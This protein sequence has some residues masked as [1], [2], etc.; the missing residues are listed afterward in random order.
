MKT[1]GVFHPSPILYMDSG[2]SRFHAQTCFDLPYKY[3]NPGCSSYKISKLASRQHSIVS[4]NLQ[5]LKSLKRSCFSSSFHRI[6]RVLHHQ[7]YQNN[8]VLT[9]M[10]QF[11]CDHP[12]KR[13]LNILKIDAKVTIVLLSNILLS[14]NMCMLYIIK[15]VHYLLCC[16]TVHHYLSNIFYLVK[17]SCI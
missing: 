16:I 10:R 3:P 12:Y 4:T 7:F 8:S 15:I 14:Y 13:H 17:V 6:Y 9:A 5:T 11:F 2:S 1:K